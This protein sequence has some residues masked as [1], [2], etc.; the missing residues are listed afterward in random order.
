MILSTDVFFPW[1]RWASVDGTDFMHSTSA[2]PLL[3]SVIIFNDKLAELSSMF[4]LD[5]RF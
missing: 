4:Y 1:S 3:L 5:Y 2:L